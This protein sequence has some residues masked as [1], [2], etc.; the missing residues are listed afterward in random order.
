MVARA[1]GRAGGGRRRPAPA[2]APLGPRPC[3]RRPASFRPC[4]APSVF[5]ARPLGRRASRLTGGRGRQSAG[6][7]VPARG[8]AGESAG[9]AARG[10]RR[11]YRARRWRSSSLAC[12]SRALSEP[13]EGRCAAAGAEGGGGAGCRQCRAAGPRRV[14]QAAPS[15]AGRGERGPGGGAGA[16]G[17]VPPA[18]AHSSGS[19]E[20]VGRGRNKRSGARLGRAGTRRWVQ[21]KP[22]RP[23]DR[24]GVCGAGSRGCPCGV[25]RAV[26]RGPGSAPWAGPRA[27]APPSLAAARFCPGSRPLSLCVAEWLRSRV[28][29]VWYFASTFSFFF[30]LLSCGLC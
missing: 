20:P 14:E 13:P 26:A 4:R 29:G 19:A 8:C 23:G 28:R 21:V 2:R 3:P 9:P 15:P 11:G 5:R 30:F 7:R 27:P 25:W 12:S 24:A 17:A 16:R 18:R 10:G 6:G 1:A 22:G